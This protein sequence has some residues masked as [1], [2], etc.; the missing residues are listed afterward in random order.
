MKRVFLTEEQ[1]AE[2]LADQKG[3]APRNG[4]F[5]GVWNREKEGTRAQSSNSPTEAK[6]NGSDDQFEVKFAF[7]VLNVLSI[8]WFF[9]ELFIPYMNLRI[10]LNVMALM[11]T[12]VINTKSRLG[13]Q[14]ESRF[15]KP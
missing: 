8:C 15:K 12:P 3:N 11:A 1:V 5:E 10:R 7:R 13:S 2:F 9:A 6:E 4:H 14:L